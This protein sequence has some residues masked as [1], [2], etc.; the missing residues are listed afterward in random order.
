MYGDTNVPGVTLSEMLAEIAK[1]LG[2]VVGADGKILKEQIPALDYLAKTLLGTANGVASLDA[3]TK[4]PVAQ[5]PALSYIPTSAKGAVNGVASLDANGDVPFAQVPP[6]LVYG[7]KYLGGTENW[8]TLSPGVYYTTGGKLGTNA[9]TGLSVYGTLVYCCGPAT[10]G[11]LQIYYGNGN[12]VIAVRSRF[13]TTQSWCAWRYFNISGT[14][15]GIA[16]APS[17]T[18]YTTRQVRNTVLSTAAAS[19]GSNGDMWFTYV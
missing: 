4:I 18:S 17:N 14:A 11:S 19:G 3:N 6:Y 5:I 15:A 9:P 8:N 1:A 10:I 13:E 16:T 7:A 12:S 2:S